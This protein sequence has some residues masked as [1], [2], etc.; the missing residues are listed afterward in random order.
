[1]SLS[2][3]DQPYICPVLYCRVLQGCAVKMTDSGRSSPKN[4]DLS[5][6]NKTSNNDDDD[7]TDIDNENDDEWQ[8]KHT[9]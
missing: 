9:W 4:D 7:N 3:S 6:C 8:W 1:M 2:V 5:F